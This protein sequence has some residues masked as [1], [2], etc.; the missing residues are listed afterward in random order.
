MRTSI[1]IDVKVQKLHETARNIAH[2]CADANLFSVTHIAQM[3]FFI[4]PRTSHARSGCSAG[5]S[6]VRHRCATAAAPAGQRDNTKP[7]LC[8]STQQNQ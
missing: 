5:A 2:R 8:V 7:Q 1:A 4:G 3:P 6:L